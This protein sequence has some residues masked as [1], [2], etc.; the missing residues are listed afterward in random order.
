MR[1]LLNTCRG[2]FH[3]IATMESFPSLS[4]SEEHVP[5]TFAAGPATVTECMQRSRAGLLLPGT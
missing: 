4:T 1:Y 3:S 5:I 2:V